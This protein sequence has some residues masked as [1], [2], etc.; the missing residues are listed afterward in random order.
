MEK[1]TTEAKIHVVQNIINQIGNT[2]NQYLIVPKTITQNS[3]R[4]IVN[5]KVT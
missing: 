4:Q 1:G 2:E 3:N 5:S